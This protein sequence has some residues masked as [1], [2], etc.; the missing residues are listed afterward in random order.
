VLVRLEELSCCCPTVA[1]QVAVLHLG[2]GDLDGTLDWLPRAFEAGAMGVHWINIDPIWDILRP[3]PR[4]AELLRRRGF[5]D[6][7]HTRP[8]N[9]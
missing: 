1:F 8:D 3:D 9:T 7:T 6:C 4:F 5:A 2:L